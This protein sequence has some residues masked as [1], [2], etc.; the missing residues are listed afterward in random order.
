MVGRSTGEI[1]V[2]KSSD[3]LARLPL[4]QGR[5]ALGVAVMLVLAGTAFAVRW[6]ADPLLPSGF[7][8]VTFFPAVI[9]TSFLF[10]VQIGSASAVICGALAWYFFI[11]PFRSF[12][13]TVASGFALAFY[14]FVVAT[15]ILLVHWMQRANHRL[16]AER[17]RN[18]ALADTRELLFRE[19][20]HRVSNNLQVAAALLM[21]QKRRVTDGEARTALDEGARRLGVIGRISRQLYHVEGTTRGLRALLEPL[22]ADVVDA[23]GKP[24]AITVTGDHDL[25]V[26][27]DAAVPVALIV[28]EAVANSIEH[29]FADREDGRIDI[30]LV[31]DG[32]TIRIDVRDDG[33]GLPDGFDVAA[34]GSLG[35]G[36]A[37]MLAEQLN[38]RFELLPGTGATARLTVPA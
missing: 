13:L 18:R 31:Q 27:S 34:S 19:L 15:D 24:V 38:G 37:T 11:P 6:F 7:P 25:A 30:D 5:P 10:G 1:S 14:V 33:H 9:I 28:A 2:T 20:Q 16:A 32:A 8:Y 21:L 4:A 3:W 26:K 35:L 23:S 12:D 22:C 17:E 36:I 29:G